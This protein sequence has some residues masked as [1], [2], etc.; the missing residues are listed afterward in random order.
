MSHGMLGRTAAAGSQAPP[1][2]PAEAKRDMSHGMP[3]RR[4]FFT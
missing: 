2:V 4:E 3:G 1:R